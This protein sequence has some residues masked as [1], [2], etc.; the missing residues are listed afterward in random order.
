MRRVACS[1]ESEIRVGL[2]GSAPVETKQAGYSLFFQSQTI[3]HSVKKIK[4]QTDRQTFFIFS[5]IY[6]ITW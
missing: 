5:Q 3:L 6:I 4:I 1:P 2:S